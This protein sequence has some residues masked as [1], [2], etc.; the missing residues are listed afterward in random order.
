MERGTLSMDRDAQG[1]EVYADLELARLALPRRVY[2]LSHIEYVIDRLTWL[3][4]HRQLVRGLRFVQE[5]RVL[6]FFFGRLEPLEDWGARLAE[7]FTADFWENLKSQNG[8]AG[9]FTAC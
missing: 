3:Y 5:P 1:N 8:S 6:R 9:G 2:T 4:Q 7:A